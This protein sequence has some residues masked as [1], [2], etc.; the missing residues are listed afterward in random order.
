MPLE[1]EVEAEEMSESWMVIKKKASPRI[2]RIKLLLFSVL[3]CFVASCFDCA[4]ACILSR[5]RSFCPR[6]SP[7]Q[8]QE[9]RSEERKGKE[10]KAKQ[11]KAEELNVSWL[12][13]QT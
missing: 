6:I 1:G 12:R 13:S 3:R 4:G 2:V 8:K 10:R 11:S 5:L 7:S 9:S